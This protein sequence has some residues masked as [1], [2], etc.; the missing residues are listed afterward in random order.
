MGRSWPK[1]ARL[2]LHIIGSSSLPGKRVRSRISLAASFNFV[3]GYS[4][5]KSF[6]DDIFDEDSDTMERF[7]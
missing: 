2:R 3:S 6:E 4:L 7:A 1:L 5:L